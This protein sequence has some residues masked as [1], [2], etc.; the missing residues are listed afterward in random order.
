M[1]STEQKFKEM[2]TI[3]EMTKKIED[4]DVGVKK[5]DKKNK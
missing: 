2:E 3:D 4:T 5:E 1:H